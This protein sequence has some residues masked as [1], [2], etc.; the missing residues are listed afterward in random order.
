I[1]GPSGRWVEAASRRGNRRGMQ[2]VVDYLPASRGRGL[3]E[4]FGPAGIFLEIFCRFPKIARCQWFGGAP[5]SRPA[6]RWDAPGA[7]AVRLLRMGGPARTSAPAPPWR[8][9]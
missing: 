1:V 6:G 7:P 3:E 2:R 4:R 8:P 5:L 9:L